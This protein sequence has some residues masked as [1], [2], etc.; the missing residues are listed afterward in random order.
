M[1]IL[2]INDTDDKLIKMII[3]K[4]SEKNDFKNNFFKN[5]FFFGILFFN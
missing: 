1:I 4:I 3:K 5:I 2:F